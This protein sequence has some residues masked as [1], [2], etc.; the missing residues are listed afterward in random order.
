MKNPRLI[1]HFYGVG[2]YIDSSTTL[3]ADTWYHV[4]YTHDGTTQTLYIDGVS[5]GAITKTLNTGASAFN[6]G[7]YI[8]ASAYF[9]GIIDECGIWGRALNTDEIVIVSV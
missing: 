4:G 2:Y 1:I 7:R 3:S 6:I 9:N 8:G 5:E